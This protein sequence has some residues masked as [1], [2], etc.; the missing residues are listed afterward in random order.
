MKS[1]NAV[2]KVKSDLFHKTKNLNLGCLTDLVLL[3][4]E[5]QLDLIYSLRTNSFSGLIEKAEAKAET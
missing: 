4:L 5:K 3:Q 2:F 1:K